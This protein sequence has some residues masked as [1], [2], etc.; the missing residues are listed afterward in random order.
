MRR[1]T[2]TP[3]CRATLMSLIRADSPMPTQIDQVARS[4]V[5]SNRSRA[6]DR[7][8]HADLGRVLVANQLGEPGSSLASETT[9]A[10]R[11]VPG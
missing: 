6:R 5:K 3:S 8:E 2:N 11:G 7:R 4:G 10:G 1:L 9:L